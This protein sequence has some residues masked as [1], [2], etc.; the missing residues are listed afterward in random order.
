MIRI[1]FTAHGDPR[2]THGALFG[3]LYLNRPRWIAVPSDG[4]CTR[5][6][7][8][9]SHSTEFVL[10]LLNPKRPGSLIA[11]S[12]SLVIMLVAAAGAIALTI[13]ALPALDRFI[14]W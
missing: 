14:K 6:G 2:G 4:F 13:A 3:G 1:N 11:L 9:L 10:G 7:A 5:N 8:I 12:L